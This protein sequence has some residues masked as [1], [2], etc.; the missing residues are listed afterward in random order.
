ME[1][2]FGGKVW[3]LTSDDDFADP[4]GPACQLTLDAI[5]EAKEAMAGGPTEEA[6]HLTF[7][8]QWLLNQFWANQDSE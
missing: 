5:Q 4:S 1:I 8:A 6:A 3:V 2:E 7:T